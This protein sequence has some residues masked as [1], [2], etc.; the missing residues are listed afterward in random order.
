MK[1]ILARTITAILLLWLAA[2]GGATPTPTPDAIT[3]TADRANIQ[4]GECTLLHWEVTEG[5]GVT[6]NDE[7]VDKAGQMEVCPSETHGYELKV[8]MGTHMETR[9]V[10]IT[11][12][13]VV[14]SM[15]SMRV[16]STPHILNISSRR[17]NFG[18]LRARPRRL[19]FS[20]S[21]A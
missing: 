4:S 18:A 10:E 2:C 11:V 5:F 15:P 12:S 1:A 19:A 8:D 7:P 9:V 16:R 14:M 13:A 6:V 21:P 20:G 17:L 3:F